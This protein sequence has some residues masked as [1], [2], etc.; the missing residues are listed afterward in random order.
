MSTTHRSTARLL[1]A[2]AAMLLVAACGSRQSPERAAVEFKGTAP[3]GSAA[4][5]AASVAPS[6]SSA[7][8]TRSAGAG[9]VSYEGYQAAVARKG[10]TVASVAARIGVSASELGAYNGLPSDHTLRDGDELVLPPR[11]GGYGGAPAPSA[12]PGQTRVAE[13]EPF[14]TSGT[15]SGT[16][17][18]TGLNTGSD[19][20]T[21][22]GIEAAPLEAAPPGGTPGSVD[23]WSPDLAAAAIER[24]QSGGQSGSIGIPPSVGAPL[25]PDPQPPVELASPQLGQYQTPD[26]D[27]GS[28]APAP[29]PVETITTPAEQSFEQAA[30]EAAEPAEPGGAQIGGAQIGD[31]QIGVAAAPP[32]SGQLRL[33]RPAT[34]PIV[35]GFQQGSG[36]VRNDGVDFASPVGSPV[37][38]AADGEVALVS[39][40]LGGLGTIV[41]VR[42]QGEYLTVYGRI[43]NVTVRKGD[44]VSQGQRI[45]VVASNPQPRMH[46][47]VRKGAESLDPERFFARA[48]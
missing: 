19:A 28:R 47:E 42:H 40:S 30:A 37:V 39:Q 20:W 12:E 38:A 22:S 15:G 31:A 33:V 25:P 6:A 35:V 36:R 24:A 16:G 21:A 14:A 23:G 7:P 9:I 29:R 44:I 3:A 13:L 5:S 2:A 27:S 10:D 41:L 1:G 26:P 8:S 46:F 11:S 43:D 45:G 4:A 17:L 34:G 48:S 18:N 32:A